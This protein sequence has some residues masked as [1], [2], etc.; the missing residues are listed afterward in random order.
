MEFPVDTQKIDFSHKEIIEKIRSEYGHTLS[1]HSFASLYLWQHAMG[2]SL[3]C[4]K[5]FF[6][7]QCGG[8][9]SNMWF[10]PC[11]NE[12]KTHSFIS[13][14]MSD[15]PFSLCYLRER[16]VK[17]LDKNFPEKWNFKRAEPS[18]EYI[19]NVSEYISLE[20]SKFSEIRR[21]IR[22]ID[23]EHDITVRKISDSTLND[24]MGVAEKWYAKEHH[25]GKDGLSDDMI[26]EI[27]L[28]ER[29]KLDISGIIMYADGVPV[30]V[31]A[32]FPLTGDTADVLIGK[33]TLDAPKGVAYYALREYLRSLDGKY[34]YCNH[35]EDLGIEGIRQ[36]KSSLCPIEKTH[37]WEADLK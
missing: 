33:C 12:Q 5:D 36:M 17:W 4:D 28:D 20:G 6:A 15:K 10:F 32:G 34:L 2:L 35:E 30:S 22:K 21:K 23:R 37:I 26:A 1:S 19:C 14:K 13:E 25:I 16:D 29:K 27:A 18:D 11:G 31:F 24:A 7:V 3:I 9:N 8:E